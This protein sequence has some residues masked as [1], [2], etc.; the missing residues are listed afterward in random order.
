MSL[1]ISLSNPSLPRRKESGTKKRREYMGISYLAR[2]RHGLVS[3]NE[4]G[5]MPSER[6]RVCLEG[7]DLE[8]FSWLLSINIDETRF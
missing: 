3:P 2:T 8:L 6:S 1:S 5:N 7:W 4:F